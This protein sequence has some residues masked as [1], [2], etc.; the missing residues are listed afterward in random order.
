MGLQV[1]RA[2]FVHAKDHFRFAGLGDDLTVGD[3]VQ[4]FDPAFLTA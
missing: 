4:V 3:R 1:Q 2:N